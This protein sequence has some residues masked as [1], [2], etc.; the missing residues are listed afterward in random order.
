MKVIGN[1]SKDEIE[2]LARETVRKYFEKPEQETKSG[3]SQ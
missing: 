1:L 2:K 3:G